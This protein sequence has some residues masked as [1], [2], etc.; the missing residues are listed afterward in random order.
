MNATTV[1]VNALIA[2]YGLNLL[3]PLPGEGVGSNRRTL[4]I[5]LRVRA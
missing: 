4:Y 2:F 1:Q 3:P 5:H